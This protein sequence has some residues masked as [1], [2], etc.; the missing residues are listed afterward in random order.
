MTI[1]GYVMVDEL[2]RW[3]HARPPF[4]LGSCHLTVDGPIDLLHSFAKRLGLRR[5]WFQD[6]ALAPHYD[7]TPRR[8]GE[9]IALGAVEVPAREQARRR[10]HLLFPIACR[11]CGKP[12]ES[13]R[14]GF[15]I[16][17]CYVCLPPPEPLPQVF[18]K[19]RPIA[20]KP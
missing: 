20:R 3:P 9:A 5:E 8:R 14:R 1:E 6:H 18:P 19:V 11:H 12:V 16:P 2:R 13:A 10:R 7:L 17:T 4:H 15:A